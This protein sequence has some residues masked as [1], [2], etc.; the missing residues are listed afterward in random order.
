FFAV[1]GWSFGNN[2][3]AEFLCHHCGAV[4]NSRGRRMRVG[5]IGL[6]VMGSAMA[7]HLAKAGHTLALYD[8]DLQ[9]AA[10]IAGHHAGAVATRSPRAGG[11]VSQVVFT[12]TPH[13]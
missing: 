4:T 2:A 10:R 5:F 13:T 12:T 6:C 1:K 7:G 9:T 11:H 8:L 3:A